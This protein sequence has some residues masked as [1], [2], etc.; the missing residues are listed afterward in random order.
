MRDG[1]RAL[2]ALAIVFA[3]F[4][5]SDPA[6]AL[7]PVEVPLASCVA[8]SADAPAPYG[9]P[10]PPDW[11]A[12]GQ[13]GCSRFAAA[14]LPVGCGNC[15]LT[16]TTCSTVASC[17]VEN[18][19][20]NWVGGGERI[21]GTVLLAI[22]GNVA[23]CTV[24]QDLG[25]RAT[26][27]CSCPAF[28]GFGPDNRCYCVDGL[29]WN[30]ATRTCDG[31]CSG[32]VTEGHCL[33]GPQKPG[34]DCADCPPRGDVT[35]GSNPINVATGIKFEAETYYRSAA[36]H[37]LSIGTV[38]ASATSLAGQ[39][40]RAGIFG[41]NRTSA[42]DRAIREIAAVGS[43]VAHATA[44]RPDGRRLDFRRISPIAFAADA[45]IADRL[46][47]APD[48]GG[49]PAG[50]RYRAAERDVIE[51]YGAAGMLLFEEDRHGRRLKHTYANGSGGH[52][53]T[54]PGSG[55]FGHVSPA[56]NAPQGWVY[57]VGPSGFLPPGRLICVTDPFGR[58]LHFQY[59]RSGRVTQIADPGSGVYRFRYDGASGGCNGELQ[60][61]A[62]TAGNLTTVEFPDGKTRAYHYN[63]LES[64]N[65]GAACAGKPPFSAGRA[66]LPNHLTGL[67]DENGARFATWTYDCEGRATSSQHADGAGRIMVAYGTP[68]P[69]QSTV[70]DPKQSRVYSFTVSHGVSRN[71][72]LSHPNA[73]GRAGAARHLYDANG[74]IAAR[75]DWNG[76]RTNYVH[77]LA[78]NLET[79]R[80]EGLTESG[81]AT[82]QT[83]TVTTEWHALLRLPQRI[84]EPLRITTLLHDA[85]GSLC[86]AR[87][88]LCSRS[89]QA[90]TDA[91]GALGFAAPAQGRPRVWSYLYDA[92]GAVLSA[93][94][95]RS[96]VP[97]TTTYSY[98][99]SGEL[100]TITNAAGHVT[101]FAAYNLHGQPTMIV[102]ANGMTIELAYD[103]RQRLLSRDAAG[104]IIGY[105]YDAAGQLTKLTLP[106]GSHLSY[107]YDPA[108]RLTSLEDNLGNRIAY[109]LDAMGNR[110]E[111]LVYDPAG[112]LAQKRSRVY[113]SLNRLFQELGAQGQATELGYDSHGNVISVKDPLLRVT[114][115]H[116]DALNRLVRSVDAA[117]GATRYAYNGLDAL[118]QVTDPRDLVTAYSL[119]GLG[120]LARQVSPDTGT[121]LNTYD[122]AGNLLTQKDAKEQVTSYAYDVL[123]RVVSI[124][125]HDGSRQDYR[126]DEATH[127]TG[128]L[129]WISESDAAG[130]LTR[131]IAYAY[132][133]HG[134]VSSETRDIGGV[135]YVAAYAYDAAGR[136]TGLTYPS[137]RTVAYTL[138]DLG[139]V[140]RIVTAKDNQSQVVVQDVSYHPFGGVKEYTLGNGQAYS[141]S[142]DLDGRIASYT[143]GAQAFGIGYDA[144]GRIE[145]I[146]DLGNAA[147]VNTYAYDELDRLT[148]AVIPGTPFGYSYDAAG[149]RL[150]KTVG[151]ATER[152]TYSPASNRVATLTPASGPARAFVFDANGSTTD[153]GLNTYAYDARGRMAR[154]T[155]GAGDT[156]YLVN[157]LGQRARKT[158]A[159]G[160]IVFHY[161][162]AGRLIGESDAA[163]A[164]RREYLYLGDIPVGIVQ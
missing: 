105:D 25:Q 63:E 87:G 97:D 41:R 111:E 100:A 37:G 88:A 118:T 30:P 120:N 159:A 18:I 74:N 54:P 2:L 5:R 57:Q 70:A 1:T 148:G 158:N 23:G 71:T 130:E 125:F 108:R 61:F 134:R 147:N 132:D 56:C 156:S 160:D 117:H 33:P 140:S 15:G 16:G 24:T 136:L 155:S 98:Q 53:A 59:D 149:N 153:D 106:G 94:G 162:R 82:P 127:G 146:A 121:T 7:G 79:A 28:A 80:I 157:A 144:A 73:A 119:D 142:I 11:Q 122:D 109:R 42:F 8:L 6:A 67:V 20:P 99:A 38:F 85:D 26:F 27:I 101:S 52:I 69:G 51:G 143:L 66:H 40:F 29:V 124:L 163:G 92:N 78:R 76:N 81:A 154:A 128:R 135:R 65:A 17:T 3:S 9:G 32:V 21:F 141:R 49:G 110:I 131:R 89:V 43:S 102:D 129:A 19:A 150:S 114:T 113:D 45:D 152:Y 75:I 10:T 123:D 93:D 34:K 31:S 77:D 138:D 139:R 12:A 46:E 164:F 22:T 95:P 83:R 13:L 14:H 60:N 126:Y 48:P 137:G 91:T 115:S 36:P 116:Y 55:A 64:V 161:D 86:G 133:L 84:A 68:A 72:A 50:F 145:F 4:S 96:D 35:A 47:R 62:C 39:P 151:A 58:Q 112:E 44:T 90:T 107:A 104:E 103:A